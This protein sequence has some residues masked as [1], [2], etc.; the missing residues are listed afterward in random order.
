MHKEP[1]APVLPKVRLS[2]VK[3][4]MFTVANIR[5]GLAVS[6]HFC[7][8][9]KHNLTKH[10]HNTVIGQL[11]RG[12]GSHCMNFSFK[13]FFILYTRLYVSFHVYN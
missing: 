7:N 6:H 9:V 8:F 12:E 1:V 3:T 11:C 13:F 5:I 2:L 10:P 4:Y